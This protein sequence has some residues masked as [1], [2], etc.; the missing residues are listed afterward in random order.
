MPLDTRSKTRLG[1]VAAAAAPIVAVQVARLL[2]GG[3]PG[4]AAA[5]IPQPAL[6]TAPATVEAA[7]LVLTAEQSRALEWLTSRRVQQT[8][9]RSPI[10]VHVP[11][12]RAD[13]LPSA[14]EE[15]LPLPKLRLGGVASRGRDTVASI[16]NRLYAIGD[17]PAQGWTITAIDGQ[18]R[19]LSLERFDGQKFELSSSGI[20]KLA[21]PK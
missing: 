4:H 1:W 3:G 5:A 19:T 10:D 14:V 6:P 13:V 2:A 16:N 21:L 18:T 8:T 20:T 9:L 11:Q 12:I 7:P 15:E 17:E